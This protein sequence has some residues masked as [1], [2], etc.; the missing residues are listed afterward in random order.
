[1]KDAAMTPRAY[2]EKLRSEAAEQN[3]IQALKRE[4][5]AAAKLAKSIQQIKRTKPLEYQITE[6]M[7]TTPPAIRARPW[8][9]AE[10]V[11][12]LQ[13]KYR[14]H[15]HAKEVGEALRRLGWQ[16]IRLW[17]DAGEGRR[18]WQLK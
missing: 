11:P 10:L 1:M 8:S 7:Q 17:G 12:R 14:D 16:R 4:A 2:I 5:E 13:G 9:I 6:L 3:R 18:V 15:P